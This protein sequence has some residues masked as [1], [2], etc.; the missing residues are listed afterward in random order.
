MK[1]FSASCAD[2]FVNGEDRR[3]AERGTI[4]MR[5]NCPPELFRNLRLD[6]GFGK[7][8]SY[9]SILHRL[10][11]FE[12]IARGKGGSVTL[13]LLEPNV[14]VGYSVYRYPDPVERWSFMRELMYEMAAVEVS[15]NFRNLGLGHRLLQL[16]LS[17]GPFEDRILYLSGFSWHWDLEGTGL[18]LTGYRHMLM[19]LYG[20]FGFRAVPTNEP[21]VTLREENFMMVKMGSKVSEYDQRRFKSLCF[22]IKRS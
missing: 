19:R 9:T 3:M 6:N 14:L 15:R 22:G 5:P 17:N 2:K 7:F 11:E 18:N 16:S 21:N 13:A 20:S 12:S 1:H 4:T 10:E 8:P